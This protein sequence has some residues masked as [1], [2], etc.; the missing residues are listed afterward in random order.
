MLGKL[1]LL[2][3]ACLVS[4][5]SLASP[6]PLEVAKET[7]TFNSSC[8]SLGTATAKIT[9]AVYQDGADYI[10]AYQISDVVGSEFS[11]FSV[12]LLNTP[13]ISNLQV[14]DLGFLTPA[15]S[16]APMAGTWGVSDSVDSVDALFMSNKIGPGETSRWLTFTSD[17]APGQGIG[18]LANLS[19]TTQS[20]ISGQVYIPMIPEPMTLV[21]LGA[22]ALVLRKKRAN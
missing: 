12:G 16:V 2:F 22:G 4:V 13:A 19:G 9:S 17:R 8:P 5:S 21:L 6:S 18:S 7:V 14:G 3:A 20:H 10:Y 1:S 11:W 15:G